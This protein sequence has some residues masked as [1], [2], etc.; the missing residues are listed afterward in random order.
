MSQSRAWRRCCFLLLAFACCAAMLCGAPAQAQ[1]AYNEALLDGRYAAHDLFVLRDRNGATATGLRDFNGD[2]RIASVVSFATRTPLTYSVDNNAHVSIF[3]PQVNF[4]AGGCIGLGG[5]LLAFSTAVA[6]QADQQVPVG[7][8]AFRLSIAEQAGYNAQTLKGA[9]SYH[10]LVYNTTTWWNVF[11]GAEINAVNRIRLQRA[12]AAPL[13]FPYVVEADGGVA[14]GAAGA[15]LA[16][17]AES[18]SLLFQT[19]NA[20]RNSDPL[21]PSGY[22]GLAILLRRGTT[23]NPFTPA[24]FLGTYV[25][26]R[27]GVGSAGPQVAALQTFTAGPGGQIRSGTDRDTVAFF[28]SGVFSL[29]NR[30]GVTGTIAESGDFAVLTR[31]NGRVQG[32]TGEAWLELWVRTA[33]GRPIPGDRDGDGLSDAEEQARGTNPAIADSDGD[34]LLDNADPRP[35]QADNIVS[36]QLSDSSVDFTVGGALP[37]PLSLALNAGTYPFFAWSLESNEAWLIPETLAGFGNAQV[38]LRV[39]PTGLAAREAPYEARVTLRAPAMRAVAPISVTLRVRPGGVPIEVSP[40]RLDFTVVKGGTLPAEKTL[41][42]SSPSTPNFNWSARANVP[43]LR[44][45]PSTGTTARDVAIAVIVDTLLPSQTLY[46]G[47]LTFEGTG[48]FSAEAE[49]SAQVLAPRGLGEVFTLESYGINATVPAG[50]FEEVTDT[51]T[52]AWE[53]GGRVHTAV[54]EAEGAPRFGPQVVSTTTQGTSIAPAL[55]LDPARREVWYTWQQRQFPEAPPLLQSRKLSLPTFELGPLFGLIGDSSSLGPPTALVQAGALYVAHASLAGLESALRTVRMS[56]SANNERSTSTLLAED[57]PTREFQTPAVAMG[58]D[59]TIALVWTEVERSAGTGQPSQSQVWFGRFT[60][61]GASLHAPS[62]VSSSPGFNEHPRLVRNADGN[63]WLIAWENSAFASASPTNVYVARVSDEGT[64]LEQP[65][66]LEAPPLSRA[67]P[68]VL[69]LPQ[70]AQYVVAW[71]SSARRLRIQ[72][73]TTEGQTLGPVL[74][75]NTLTQANAVAL[76]SNHARGEYLLVATGDSVEAVRIPMGSADED[77]DGLPNAYELRYGL[78]PFDDTGRDGASGDPDADGLT[79][80]EEFNIGTDPAKADTDGDGLSDAEEDSNRNG[81]LDPGETNPLAADTDGDGAP[82]GAEFYGGADPRDAASRPAPGIIRA[83]Y[84]AF[85]PGIA[86]PLEVHVYVAT[87][88]RYALSATVPAGWSSTLQGDAERDLAPGMHV[89]AFQTTAL[90]PITPQNSHG[91]F[92]FQ[93]SGGASPSALAVTLVCDVRNTAGPAGISVRALA[94]RYAPVLRMDRDERHFPVNVESAI[95]SAQLRIDSARTLRNTPTPELL[96]R[97]PHAAAA[98]DLPGEE[99]ESLFAAYQSLDPAPAPTLYY[100]LA[101]LAA[102]SAAPNVPEGRFV[103]QYYGYFFAS[104]WALRTPGTYRHEG[105]WQLFQIILNPTGTPESAS[106]TQQWQAARAGSAN[107]GATTPWAQVETDAQGRPRLFVSAGGHSLHFRPGASRTMLGGENQDGLGTWL[108]P[109]GAGDPALAQYPDTRAY[110]LAGLPRAAEPGL[111]PWLVF[112]GTWGQRQYPAGPLD[113]PELATQ[114]GPLGPLFLGTG[115]A[116]G[117]AGKVR[118]LWTDPHAFTV[119]SIPIA[120]PGTTIYRAKF[121]D[122]PEGSIAVLLDS[123]GRIYRGSLDAT[124][125]ANIAA[126]VGSYILCVADS[127]GLLRETFAGAVRFDLDWGPLR[128]FRGRAG[129]LN[130]LGTFADNGEGLYG[131]GNFAELDSDGDGISDAADTDIDGDGIANALDSDPQGDGWNDDYQV[132]DA[133]GDGVPRYYDANETEIAGHP[134][135]NDAPDHDRD[136]FID[137]LDL[138]IDNDGFDNDAERAAG[139]NPYLFIDTPLQKAG[140]IDQD[141]G[142]DAAD[143]QR[144]INIALLRAPFTPLADFDESGAIDAR[145]LQEALLALVRDRQR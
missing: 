1:S 37:E 79:N 90:V 70:A 50:I 86:A 96:A 99:I 127:N 23:Q 116:A 41:R 57:S 103:L 92:Q 75:F 88:G 10:A 68:D 95:A 52:L 48:G 89:Y 51:Y 25:A 144:V 133:N 100:T 110:A 64:F 101:P 112:A 66:Q 107:G 58:D 29:A 113:R 7:Y 84:G 44:I 78:D 102:F 131:S 3:D 46:R 67:R 126:P 118:S 140:D 69:T 6:A 122:R 76:V 28:D 16:S 128:V 114:D 14:I 139:S 35:L 125:T 60:L 54:I 104:E 26:L 109:D 106:I 115:A 8:G 130:D 47:V 77:G 97:L 72:R 33:G 74:S 134:G 21:Y 59:N 82:D 17:A 45:T 73:F 27:L 93:L 39:D 123:R 71:P 34:G 65:R 42:L 111:P 22:Q 63:A 83:S 56:L 32:S 94:E 98:L 11:G 136:G 137:A 87:P 105:D 55:A 108:V 85:P 129:S 40:Q 141:G 61:A 9:Y 24:R 38:A 145:D 81:M 20:A 31:D 143:I 5:E 135:T 49:V 80:I 121:P 117:I 30:P 138:D 120:A 119:N 43:W 132:Q 19:V 36:A 142:I 62:Q 53:N 2:G 15:Q 13:D 18:G 91:D 12:N 4:G 124:G